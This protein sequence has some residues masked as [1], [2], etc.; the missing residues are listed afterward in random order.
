M[1]S[2]PKHLA[3]YPDRDLDCQMTLEAPFQQIIDAAEQAGWTRIEAITAMQELAYNQ[4]AAEEEN[5]KTE[6]L[7]EA[8]T[9]TKH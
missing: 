6:L 7:I 1:I 4:L 2:R 8:A 9:N 5:T 3:P